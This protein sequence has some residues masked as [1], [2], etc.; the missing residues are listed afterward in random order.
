MSRRIC[1]ALL[2]LTLAACHAGAP[3]LDVC[4]ADDALAAALVGG[5]LQIEVRD[6][7]GTP[8]ASARVPADRPS[9]AALGAAPDG[10]WVVVEGLDAGGAPVAGGAARIAGGGACVCLG[11]TTWYA[12][13]SWQDGTGAFHDGPSADF[14]VQKADPP[15][16][17]LARPLALDRARVQPGEVVRATAAYENRGAAAVDVR[18]I[19]VLARPPGATHAAGLVSD[20]SP[21]AVGRVAPGQVVD[22]DVTRTFGA[23]DAPGSWR[24]FTRLT[25]RLGVTHDGPEVSLAVGGG[26]ADPLV[27][28]RPP[29]LDHAWVRPP[30]ALHVAVSYRNDGTAPL[31]IQQL[32]LTTRPPGGSNAGGPY[33]DLSPRLGSTTIGPGQTIDVA[34]DRMFPTSDDPCADVVCTVPA[35][36]CALGPRAL[37]GTP[38]R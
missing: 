1:E 37:R 11:R 22:V 6:P 32:V 24:L 18:G 16:L 27:P 26:E 23:D 38:R 15:G 31:T 29:V 36:A 35:G 10:T 9:H 17:R 13:A 19:A 25:D 21:V 5:Q 33:D 28:A 20:F 12:Y 4:P 14:F 34:A 30:D 7:D 8:R 3:S 2:A